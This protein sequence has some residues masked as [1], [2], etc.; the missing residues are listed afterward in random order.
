MVRGSP[1][2]CISTTGRP[3][4]AATSR[5][6]GSCVKAGDVVDD[7]R[8]G[9]RCPAHHLGIAGVD[10]QRN[11]NPFRQPL[12]DGQHAPAFFLACRS[13]PS[14]AGSDPRRC[15]ECRPLRPRAAAPWAMAASGARYWPPSE[16]LSG[17]TLTTPMTRGRSNA[18]PAIGTRGCCRRCRACVTASI[19]VGQQFSGRNA[20]G[21]GRSRPSRSISSA[22]ANSRS[23]RPATSSP[24]AGVDDSTRPIG[25][26]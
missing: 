16:K 15:R 13:G 4:A 6:C 2:A 22:A 21:A 1:C 24:A 19:F 10:R 17:V 8:T 26:M 9:L 3:V 5:L 14:R 12:D 11:A 18:R 25:R 7:A 20:S 23:L